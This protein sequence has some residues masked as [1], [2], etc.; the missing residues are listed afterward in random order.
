[1]PYLLND[2]TQFGNPVLIPRA[3]ALIVVGPPMSDAECAAINAYEYKPI[4]L[5]NAAHRRS[6]M[7][8][9]W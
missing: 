7:A 1:M 8:T 2:A 5:P 6:D 4:S 3:L 9:P